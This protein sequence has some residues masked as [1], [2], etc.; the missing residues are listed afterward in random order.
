MS[1]LFFSVAGS[2]HC[3]PSNCSPVSS[4]D[5]SVFVSG[6]RFAPPFVLSAEVGGLA[7]RAILLHA[8]A[9]YDTRRLS[10]RGFRRGE[11]RGQST[12]AFKRLRP[13]WLCAQNQGFSSPRRFAAPRGSRRKEVPGAKTF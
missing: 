8:E 7:L 10:A 11:A 1:G 2:I 13:L 3:V 4:N 12:G 6:L 5:A 9:L